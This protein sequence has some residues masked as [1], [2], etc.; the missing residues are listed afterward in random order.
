MARARTPASRSAHGIFHVPVF[1]ILR[2]FMGRFFPWVMAPAVPE[3]SRA[4]PRS[5]LLQP[6]RKAVFSFASGR[7]TS[8][9]SISREAVLKCSSAEAAPWLYVTVAVS[10][11]PPAISKVPLPSPANGKKSHAGMGCRISRSETGSLSPS[12]TIAVLLPLGNHSSL[13]VTVSSDGASAPAGG[14]S[15]QDAGQ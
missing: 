10:G 6:F 5:W 7:R 14:K 2:R 8:F 12:R 1:S 11:T 15:R 3:R 13:D 4:V 9:R